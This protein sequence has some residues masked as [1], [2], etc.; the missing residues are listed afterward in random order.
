[1]KEVAVSG[2]DH[3]GFVLVGCLDDVFVSD[4]AT[5]LDRGSRS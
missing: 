4:G 1:M 5:W 3:G 2:K